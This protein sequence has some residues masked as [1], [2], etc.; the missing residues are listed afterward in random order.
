M[1][2]YWFWWLLLFVSPVVYA[3]A[4][5][6]EFWEY[7]ADYSDE[8]GEVVDPLELDEAIASKEQAEAEQPAKDTVVKSSL[9]KSASDKSVPEQGN[10]KN[11]DLK[12]TN[13]SSAATASHKGATL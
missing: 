10:M 2:R 8:N 5:S 4:P 12:A 3:A 11:A 1:P 7:M 6:Q 13:K 9:V